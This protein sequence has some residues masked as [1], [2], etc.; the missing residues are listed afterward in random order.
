MSDSKD[1][2]L[3]DGLNL[4]EN[5]ELAE[6][7]PGDDVDAMADIVDLLDDDEVLVPETDGLEVA[8]GGS[9]TVESPP[10]AETQPDAAAESLPDKKPKKRRNKP[11]AKV[12]DEPAAAVSV[13]D[14]EAVDLYENITASVGAVVLDAGVL[15]IRASKVVIETRN[16]TFSS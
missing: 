12:A 9:E 13:S 2:D 14:K 8:T 7:V 10:V 11:K 15:R 1:N 16:I 6:E 4:I 5:D 3:L